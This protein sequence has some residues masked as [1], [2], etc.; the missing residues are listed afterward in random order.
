MRTVAV[1]VALLALAAP[2]AAHEPVP[3]DDGEPTARAAQ[4]TAPPSTPRA[5]CGPGSD[6]EPGMQG[7]VAAD[8]PG[9][10]DGFR[11]NTE[12]V[13]REGVSGGFKALRYVDEAGR[14]CAF[15]DTTLMFPTNV[16]GLSGQ[17]TGVAVLDMT[18][19]A[20]PVRTDTLVTPAMQT[21]HESLEL[22]RRRGLLAA[23]TGNAIAY[24]GA[25][26]VY[27]VSEDCRKPVLQSVSATGG[28]GHESGFA[29]DGNTF[30][31]TSI[32]TGEVT[33][34]DVTDP[35]AP[36]V[37]WSGDY[38]SHGLMVSDDGNRLYLAMGAGF[39]AG[40]GLLILDSSEVQ[41]R[42]PN[43]Q[44]REVGSVN[45][46][47]STIP[48]VAIPVTIGGRPFA[49]EVD[50]F[51]AGEDGE[52]TQHGI[53]VGAARIIDLADEARPKVISNLR[54]EVHQPENREATR[55]D[56]GTFS[57]VQGYAAHYCDVPS[58]TDPG[59]V[60]CSFILSG[61]RVFDI[62]DPY[63]PKELA[64]FVAPPAQSNSSGGQSTNYA[65]S[66]PA[67]NPERSEIW[68]SDGNAGF[69]NVRLTN[70]VWPFRGGG[71]AGG[72]GGGAAGCVST[73]GL[74]SVSAAP[75]GGGLRIAFTRRAGDLPVD[76]EVF[77]VAKGRRVVREQRVA[78]FASAPGRADVARAGRP[79]RHVLRPLQ[80]HARRPPGRRAA[81][82]A[83]AARRAV[84][85]AA[86]ATTGAPR[87]GC[88]GSSS[89]SGPV[90]GG[91]RGTPL[92]I[93]YRLR[94]GARVSVVVTR[95]GRVVRRFRTGHGGGRAVTYRLRVPSRGLRRG[96]YGVRL[97]ARGSS[98]RVVATLRA[99]RL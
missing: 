31:V 74:R 33:A 79:G 35:K 11:C 43:P 71:G 40:A 29:P 53:R 81:D 88:C 82:R 26:D 69:Y 21:P 36:K 41:A 66:R 1:L 19:P 2:A 86:R 34:I 39:F 56:P 23:V 87:A 83:R 60:A 76:V 92:R 44:V 24:P 65:M 75:R 96:S 4:F 94:A 90:F 68:Y 70:G 14:E 91:R 6:P 78:R 49:V 3:S 73:A 8:A 10:E 50:E 27:D 95:G 67:F 63:H 64:Y 38:K 9:R 61:L 17:P 55:N 51:S 18:D 77:Q 99:R 45:W 84:R 13:G 52:A 16:L 47:E 28:F 15:Y 30:Y 12:L 32:S 7:R 25:V 5:D 54:L 85:P 46:P 22:N 97:G 93:A 37:V 89:S 20:R 98:D 62:R 42:K 72:P 57:P 59:I 80:P 58:R 48:Q